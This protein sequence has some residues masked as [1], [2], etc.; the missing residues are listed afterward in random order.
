MDYASFQ[1]QKLRVGEMLTM[2]FHFH[3]HAPRVRVPLS[4]DNHDNAKMH[5]HVRRFHFCRVSKLPCTF[6]HDRGAEKD[7]HFGSVRLP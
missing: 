2:Q 4:S 5:S 1:L 7:G 3:M 6:Q